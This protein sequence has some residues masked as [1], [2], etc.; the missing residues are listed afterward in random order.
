MRLFQVIIPSLCIDI[1][2]TM[3]KGKGTDA[4]SYRGD[5]QASCSLYRTTRF[6]R[7][8]IHSCEQVTMIDPAMGV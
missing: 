2:Y 4:R 1:K 7:P 3:D 6:E 5:M 8:Q